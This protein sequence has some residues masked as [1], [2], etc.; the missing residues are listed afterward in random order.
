VYQILSYSLFTHSIR[1]TDV[2]SAGNPKWFLQEQ[3]IK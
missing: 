1:N 3:L 2:K